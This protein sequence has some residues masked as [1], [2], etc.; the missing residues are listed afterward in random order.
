[1]TPRK[2][3]ALQ[4]L[5]VCRTQAEAAKLAG[6]G[7]ST[8]QGYLKEPEFMQRYREAF[9][10][11]VESAARE[12]QSAAYKTIRANASLDGLDRRNIDTEAADLARRDLAANRITASDLGAAIERHAAELSEKR[13]DEKASAQ[14]FNAMIRGAM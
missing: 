9:G 7:I 10:G 1:M 3:K 11:L 8:L 6:V 13:K 5:L 12:A 14:L 4:A 2:E